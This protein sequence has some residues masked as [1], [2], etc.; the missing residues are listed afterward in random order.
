MATCKTCGTHVVEDK[1]RLAQM[2]AGESIYCSR[3]CSARSRAKKVP[4][5]V[6][7]A[8][9]EA[10]FELNHTQ[11]WKLTTGKATA[12]WC[13]RSCK[14][15][16]FNKHSD[17]VK[18][19]R[20]SDAARESARQRLAKFNWL[21]TPEAVEK[22]RSIRIARGTHKG[23][24]P[25]VIGGNGRGLTEPQKALAGALGWETEVVVLTGTKG[26]GVPSHYKVD[27]ASKEAKIAIEVDGRSHR[28]RIV[29]ERDLKKSRFLESRGWRV[30]R[31]SNEEV[32]A[33]LARC[34]EMVTSMT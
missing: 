25:K 8:E 21:Q 29:A 16:F 23:K 12:F 10:D 15:R 26:N 28:S 14:A 6:S 33:N 2:S 9:C 17:A 13:S 7:C 18:E 22:N 1:R 19:A 11:N 32:M 5:M 20:S 30:L 27:I 3:A 31:F 34:V 24:A 4:I